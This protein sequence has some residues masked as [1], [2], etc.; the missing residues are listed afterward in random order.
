MHI[1]ERT[2]ALVTAAHLPYRFV[3]L[4]SL[5][6]FAQVF[7]DLGAAYGCVPALDFIEGCVIV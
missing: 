3:K 7:I 6:N 1:R 5:K 2:A 4:E